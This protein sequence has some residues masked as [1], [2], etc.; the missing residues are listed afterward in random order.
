MILKDNLKRVRKAKRWTQQM[1]ADKAGVPQ[2]LI[3]ELETGNR[4]STDSLPDIA[5]ALDVPV[6][7][8]DPRFEVAP[9]VS[10]ARVKDPILSL[11]QVLV[12]SILR[13]RAVD[14]PRIDPAKDTLELSKLLLEA[15]EQPP[16]ATAGVT[17]DQA[18]RQQFAEIIGR[19]GSPAH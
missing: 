4:R 2:S 19:Y 11:V 12:F 13:F 9:K 14:N 7:H 16:D 5:N 1:L 18:L 6:A 17:A 3:S 8:L 15:I 10:A